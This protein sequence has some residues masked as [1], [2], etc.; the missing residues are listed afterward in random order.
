MAGMG[1]EE[2]CEGRTKGVTLTHGTRQHGWR[3]KIELLY[4]IG[5]LK[6]EPDHADRLMKQAMCFMMESFQ[7]LKAR[8]APGH[9]EKEQ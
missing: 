5:G 3:Y 4:D 7:T 6:K 8:E 9:V 1:K 2:D